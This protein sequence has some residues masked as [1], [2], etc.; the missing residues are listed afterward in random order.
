MQNAF[1]AK[2]YWKCDKDLKPVVLNQGAAELLA[3][4]KNIS[5]VAN[6]WTRRLFY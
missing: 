1:I 2:K 6:L 5:G 4:V 3:A